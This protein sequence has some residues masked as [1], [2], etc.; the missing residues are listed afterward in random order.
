M[1]E[2]PEAVLKA[3]QDG[4]GGRRLVVVGDL[5]LDR[6][7]R[8]RVERI[9]PEAPVPVLRL[10]QRAETA[11]GAANVARNLRALGLEV[12]VGGVTGADAG[13]AA[14]IEALQ[15]DGIH[16]GAVLPIK[17]RATTIKTRVIGDHQQMLR[18][19][20]EQ[21]DALRRTDEARLCEGILPALSTAAAL[22]LSDYAKG[23]L[24]PG[25]CRTLIWAAQARG[26]P[27]LVDP[28]GRDFAKYAGATALT[29][30]RSE[31]AQA[32]GERIEALEGLL[33][34]APALRRDLGLDFL[35]VTLGELGLALIEETGCRRIPA[36]AREVFDVSGAGDTAIATLTAGLAARLGRNDSAHLAN[37]AAGVVVGK[38]GTASI[39]RAQLLA[40]IRG[41]SA[42]EQ[43]AKIVS[44][45]AARVL[46]EDWRAAGERL[47]FTNGCFDLLHA[48]HVR[49]LEQARR[50]G[51]RLLVGLNTDRSVRA[52]KGPGRP[53]IGEADRARVLAALA[54]V[55]AVVLFD[56]DTPLELIQ[57]LRPE[58]LVKGADYRE[59]EVV[60][61][62]E[63]RDWG[64]Q[65]VLIPLVENHST[66]RTLER[67]K[68]PSGSCP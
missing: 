18:I 67:L 6:Y 28:K 2:A 48:G 63:V 9:S 22:V 53:V 54:A 51:R 64:G 61:A 52:L 66:T 27:V 17:D 57:A 55:D 62:R 15:A 65:V 50:H 23:V 20:E 36:L 16:T 45:D 14:L 32:L 25:L 46:V 37:L 5:M 38:V 26:V 47:V 1:F 8:G 4:F 40:A 59:D 33:A 24:S 3:V 19:D 68:P 31:L 29:P 12:Q 34:R 56:Q 49:Y 10:E 13:R 43:A 35:A 11:G 30:N 21:T 60:G 39:T 42:L 44:Q 7:L 58:V 41:E